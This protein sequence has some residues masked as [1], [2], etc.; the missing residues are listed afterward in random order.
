MSAAL[1]SIQGL[2]FDHKILDAD[3]DRVPPVI[4]LLTRD[5]AAE[6]LHVSESTVVRLGRSGAI[7]EIRVGKR[8]IRIDPAS[9]ER[10]IRARRR[11]MREAA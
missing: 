6:R 4:P 7:T 1:R 9:V 2:A 5:E 8:G 3:K 11:P 10:Y